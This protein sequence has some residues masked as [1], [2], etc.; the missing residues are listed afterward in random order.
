MK[1]RVSVCV[2][3]CVAREGGRGVDDY[4]DDDRVQRFSW[5]RRAKNEPRSTTWRNC[6]GT[7]FRVSDVSNCGIQGIHT[8]SGRVL[9]YVSRV[10]PSVDLSSSSDS[11]H[12][13]RDIIILA[14]AELWLIA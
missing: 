7:H 2:S 12:S 14:P 8:H 4:D 1:K 11:N 9:P 13:T 5:A 3:V 10:L 6:L